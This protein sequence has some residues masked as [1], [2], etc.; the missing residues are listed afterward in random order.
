MRSS[1]PVLSDFKPG[2]KGDLVLVGGM[3]S[4]AVGLADCR[5]QSPLARRPILIGRCEAPLSLRSL[6]RSGSHQREAPLFLSEAPLAQ[7][8]DRD[9]TA[10]KGDCPLQ[11]ARP[12]VGDLICWW[13]LHFRILWKPPHGSICA[14]RQRLLL[15]IGFVLNFQAEYGGGHAEKDDGAEKRRRPSR[16]RPAKAEKDGE[17]ASRRNGGGLRGESSR[18][19]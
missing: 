4:S 7:P 15:C 17:E 14:E 9:R 13:A 19:S 1:L 8:F 10:S 18:R 2:A 5:G 3:G 16:R 12:T 11:S 6:L